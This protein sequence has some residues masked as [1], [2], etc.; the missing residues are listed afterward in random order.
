MGVR[1]NSNNFPFVEIGTRMVGVIVKAIPDPA[2]NM[3][4]LV[5][6]RFGQDRLSRAIWTDD[7]P[8]LSRIY[9]PIGMFKEEVLANS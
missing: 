1:R 7:S 5:T 9:L 4:D 2:M 8:M 6:E 3:G